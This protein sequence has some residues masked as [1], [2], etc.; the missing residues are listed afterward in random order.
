MEAC[1]SGSMFQGLLPN[2]WN[3]YATTASN[4][5]ESSYATY[6]PDDFPAPPVEFADAGICLGDTYSVAWLEDR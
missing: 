6:C 3:I 2:N 1:E 4:A 5:E